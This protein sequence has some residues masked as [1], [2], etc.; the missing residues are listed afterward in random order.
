MD[1]SSRPSSRKKRK[2]LIALGVLLVVGALGGWFVWYH[3]FRELPQPAWITE[4]PRNEFLYASMK[5][6]LKE[7]ARRLAA[8]ATMR[9]WSDMECSSRGG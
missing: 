8:K 5:L 7:P 1:A 9:G 2:I 4:D 6:R 3:L